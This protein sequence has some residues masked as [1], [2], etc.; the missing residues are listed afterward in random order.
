MREDAA[1]DD[2]DRAGQPAPDVGGFDL[3]ALPGDFIADP[4][5]YFAALRE[6]SPIHRMGDGSYLLTRYDDCVA[7]YRDPANWSSDKKLDFKPKFGDSPLYEHHTTSLVFRDP[8]DHTRIRRLF[9]AAFTPKALAVLEPRVEAL[10]D[11]Y[12]DHFEEAGAID[13]VTDFAWR[14]PVDVICDMLGVPAPDRAR[15]RDWAQAILG[16]LEPTLSAAAFAEGCGAVEDFKRYLRELVAFRR[17]NPTDG[18]SGEVLTAL[19]EAEADGER[20]TELELLHQCIFLLNA[21][22]ETSTNMLAHG[23]HE[24]LR[25]PE[26]AARLRA[27]PGRAQGCVEEVLRYQSPIQINNRRAVRD[28]TLGGQ[29]VPAGAV[30]HLMIGAANRDGTQ[31]PAPERFDI[32]RKPNRHLAFGVGI[33]ICA[34]NTLARIEGRVAISRITARFPGLRATG[35]AKLGNRIRFRGIESLPLAI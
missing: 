22:H 33:H 26:Q 6:Q 14:L 35:P 19:I 5:R 10:V 9:Q 13:A 12:L 34:G 29:P 17:R 20:L 21:G 1:N 32:E 4:Y 7:V 24:L 25:H 23:I 11:G 28:V 16:G 15:I 18:R 2:D 30:V 8:P 31:F 3:R 27:D